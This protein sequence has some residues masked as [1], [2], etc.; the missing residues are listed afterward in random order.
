[1]TKQ[2][3]CIIVSNNKKLVRKRGDDKLTIKK[4]NSVV[5]DNLRDYI[6]EN[7]LKQTAIASRAGYTVQQFN[8]MLNGRRIMKANDIERIIEATGVDAN[9]LFRSRES[10]A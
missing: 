8:D 10:L 7:G 4:S 3:T 9:M 1:M 5:A 6:D 2:E